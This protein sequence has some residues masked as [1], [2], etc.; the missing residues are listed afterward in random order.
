MKFY[1]NILRHVNMVPK[2]VTDLANEH[3]KLHIFLQFCYYLAVSNNLT[4]TKLFQ[5]CS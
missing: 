5:N 1:T 2:T 4:L 3:N